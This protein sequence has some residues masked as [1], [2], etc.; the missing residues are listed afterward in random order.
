MQNSPVEVVV[1]EGFPLRIT[2]EVLAAAFWGM[3]CVQQ[4]DFFQ[5]LAKRIEQDSPEAYG[6]GELQWCGLKQELR[7]PGRELANQMH[8]A[9]SAFSYDFWPHKTDGA[10]TGL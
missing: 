10:R 2:P 1:A 9:L 5:V 7:Q 8:M 6:F 3:D 4:A